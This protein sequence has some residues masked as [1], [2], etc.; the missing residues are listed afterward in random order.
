MLSKSEIAGLLAEE[1]FG[2]KA[3]INDLLTVL[4][5]IAQEEIEAGEGFKIPNLVTIDWTYTAPRKKGEMYKKGETY[6]GFGG[7]ETVAEADSKERKAAVKLVAKPAAAIKRS[8]PKPLSDRKAQS[9]FLASAA[10]KN[11]VKRKAR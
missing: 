6:I 5:E 4:A 7:V 3:A 2:S 8:V 10:G 1:G 9:R 11:V